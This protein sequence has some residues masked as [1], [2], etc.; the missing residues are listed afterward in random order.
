MLY[1][2]VD[3]VMKQLSA[4][5]GRLITLREQNRPDKS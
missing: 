1:N 4:A 2:T 3:V 5:Y